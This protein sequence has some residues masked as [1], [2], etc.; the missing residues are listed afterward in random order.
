[1]KNIFLLSSLFFLLSC[2]FYSM[3][4]SIPPHIKSI[5][6]PLM[7]NETAE[8]GLAEDITDGILGEFVEAGILSITDENIAHSILRGTVK[9]VN[10]G[11]YTYSKQESVSEFRY[12]IDVKLEWYDVSQDKNLLEGTY[13]GFGAYGLSGDIGSDGIDNDN[14]GKIDND[15]DDEFGEP[16]AFATKVA[17]RKIA[18][19]ILNDIMTTW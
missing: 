8:F 9:K 17:V 10:E 3:A 14:D 11:P 19:D 15:D 5:A 13:S 18:Q 1:M 7:E 4:G 16:R 6:I 2:G 12:K